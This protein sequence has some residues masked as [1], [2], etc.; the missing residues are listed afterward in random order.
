MKFTN[1]D[2]RNKLRTVTWSPSVAACCCK[3][4]L[5]T[6]VLE[7]YTSV[8][9]GSHLTRFDVV[10]KEILQSIDGITVGKTA[11]K[12]VL[13]VVHF[14]TCIGSLPLTQR[15]ESFPQVR[16]PGFS[17]YFL[18]FLANFTSLNFRFV[19][20]FLIWNVGVIIVPTQR[21]MWGLNN[22]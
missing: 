2:H 3:Q 16:M 6:L 21:V 19:F 1:S 20:F 7:I 11:K 9:I 4:M 22:L 15:I 5:K 17:F 10:L 14:P 18:Y 12:Q 8:T 13:L